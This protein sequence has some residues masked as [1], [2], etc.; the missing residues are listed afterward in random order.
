M[1]SIPV[2]FAFDVSC[3]Y[4]L[5]LYRHRIPLHDN[6]LMIL[7]Y[8]SVSTP[9]L[10]FEVCGSNQYLQIEVSSYEL[11]AHIVP[12]TVLQLEISPVYQAL[13]NAY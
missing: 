4:T 9:E 1:L 12:M 10:E 5:P 6:L 3:G 13:Y 7:T 8:L 11:S 2:H